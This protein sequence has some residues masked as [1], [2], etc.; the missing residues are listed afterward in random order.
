[1]VVSTYQVRNFQSTV[2]VTYRLIT[3]SD[4]LVGYVLQLGRLS[5][6]YR[7]YLDPDSEFISRLYRLNSPS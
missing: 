1:M 2:H 6:G 3:A 5:G 7:I 4:Y